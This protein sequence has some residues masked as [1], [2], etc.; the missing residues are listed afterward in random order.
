[1]HETNDWLVLPYELSG[2]SIT[3]LQQN[4]PELAGLLGRLAPYVKAEDDLPTG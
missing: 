3:E 4:R 2:F 1:M